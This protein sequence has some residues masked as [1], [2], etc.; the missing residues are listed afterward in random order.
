MADTDKGDGL[1]QRKTGMSVGANT[2]SKGDDEFFTALANSGMIPASVKPTV[3]ALAPYWSAITWFFTEFCHYSHVMY[4]KAMEIWVMLSPYK[5]ELLI[6]SFI[7][8]IM[9]FFGGS[10]LTTIAAVEAYKLCGYESSITCIKNLYEDF[11]RFSLAN[12]VDDAVDDN[13][14]GVAD[15]KQIPKSELATRKTLLF[16][17][18]IDPKRVSEAI[19]GLNAGCLAVIATLKLQFAKSITLGQAIGSV[20]EKPALKYGVPIVEN[21]LPNEYKRWAG[22]IISYPIKSAAIS[23]AWLIQRT[24]SAFH[25]AVRGGNMFGKNIIEYLNK[26]D[27]IKLDAKDTI[28]DEVLGY[29][30][31]ALG[32]YFQ[33]SYG[34][35]LPWF[36]AIPLFPFSII[37]TYLMWVVNSK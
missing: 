18:T 12:K 2:A 33:L 28:L 9:C 17:R 11:S 7:G 27:Y 15:V 26:M 37:E 10:F 35:S 23:L 30:F 36:L 1:R 32:L 22:P 16:L 13:N 4:E 20:V 31:A 14:D 19:A 21:L 3:L 25:S 6:P 24:I 34:F 29:A 8:L 5:P